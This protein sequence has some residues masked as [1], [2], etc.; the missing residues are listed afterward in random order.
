[1]YN[2]KSPL[3]FSEFSDDEFQDLVCDVLRENFRIMD[4]RVFG[5][6]GFKQYG[7]DVLA[8]YHGKEGTHCAV[9]AK[10]YKAYTVGNLNSALKEFLKH[11]DLW[12]SKGVGL[13]ILAFSC[14][15]NTPKFL[16]RAADFRNILFRD[17]GM[18]F[19]IWDQVVV[20]DGV[21][22]F[23]HV[24]SKYIRSHDVLDLLCGSDPQERA[25]MRL[26]RQEKEGLTFPPFEMDWEGDVS[27]Q[28]L[29]ALRQD[30][31]AGRSSHA[32]SRLRALQ[33][34]PGWLERRPEK[35][36]AFLRMAASLHLNV[37]GNEVAAR[38]AASEARTLAPH[39]N[40]LIF[41][42][43]LL[44]HQGHP[45][46]ALSLARTLET[47]PGA[48][49]AA[50]LLLELERPEDVLPVLDGRS[51]SDHDAELDRL[52]ALALAS[53]G[54]HQD[55]LALVKAR[56]TV[57]PQAVYLR[58]L[59]GILHYQLA[60]SP[61]LRT[62]ARLYAPL[63]ITP[64]L[65]R[66][67]AEGLSHIGSA[68]QAFEG[69]HNLTD[70]DVSFRIHSDLWWI[71]SLSV[72]EYDELR[73]QALVHDHLRGGTL[74]PEMALWVTFKHWPV[75]LS[76]HLGQLESHAS[77]NGPL[78]VVAWHLSLNDLDQA[79][80]I[81]NAHAQRLDE[82]DALVFRS[83]RN[84][85]ALRR[86]PPIPTL[87]SKLVEIDRAVHQLRE[88]IA[89]TGE[90]GEAV[91]DLLTYGVWWA[92]QELG[93]GLVERLQTPGAV[94]L[95]MMAAA[96]AGDHSRVLSLREANGVLLTGATLPTFIRQSVTQA[97]VLQGELPTAL[98]DAE[99][100]AREHPTAAHLLNL[101]RLYSA[102]ARMN[103][104]EPLLQRLLKV[105][106]A[107]F[108]DLLS[109]CSF[110]FAIND[111]RLAQRLYGQAARMWEAGPY[112]E[113][114]VL[115]G[116]QHGLKIGEAQMERFQMLVAT[117]KARRVRTF[118][119]DE[120]MALFRGPDPAAAVY[121]RGEVSVHHWRDSDPVTLLRTVLGDGGVPPLYSRSGTLRGRFRM[122]GDDRRRVLR[123]DLTGLLTC[124]QLGLLEQ[125][126]RQFSVC[127]VHE[128][129]SVL[130]Q[131][132]AG[133]DSS[134]PHR[135]LLNDLQGWLRDL[136]QDGRLRY[137]ATP[138]RASEMQAG[139]IL[140]GMAVL[141][142][143]PVG[144]DEQ[145]WVDDRW[146]Q[147]AA[148]SHGAAVTDT[149]GVLHDLH[150][151][152][153]ID[154]HAL[155]SRLQIL[156]R[157]G[158][159]FVP[160]TEQE[161]VYWCLQAPMAES[162]LTETEDLAL[163]RRYYAGV[164]G[165]DSPLQ[166]VQ[167]LEGRVVTGELPFVL[168]FLHESRH[169]LALAFRHPERAEAMAEWLFAHILLD[170]AALAVL[171][172]AFHPNGRDMDTLR[173]HDVTDLAMAALTFTE[174]QAAQFHRWLNRTLLQPR[175]ALDPLLPQRVAR[176]WHAQVADLRRDAAFPEQQAIG[177][178][179]NRI[180]DRLPFLHAAALNDPAYL[181][182][183]G[184]VQVQFVTWDGTALP[185]PDLWRTFPK[186]V[187]R[188][189]VPR[190][191]TDRAG[192]RWTLVWLPSKACVEVRPDG[193]EG[194]PFHFLPEELWLSMPKMSEREPFVREVLSALD[195]PA[196]EDPRVQTMLTG[197]T[198]L[199]RM[200]AFKTLEE[201]SSS[202]YYQALQKRLDT[203]P[204]RYPVSMDGWI[205]DDPTLILRHARLESLLTDPARPFAEQMRQ[206]AKT[207]IGDFGALEAAGRLL[208]L[209][210]ALPEEVAVALG[211]EQ[212]LSDL[213]ALWRV[214]KAS[215]TPV[216]LAHLVRLLGEATPQNR[217]LRV[218][219]ART[220]LSPGAHQATLA[221]KRALVWTVERLHTAVPSW[222]LSARL[223]AAWLHG[224]RLYISLLRA[225]VQ[226]ERMV[227]LFSE[228]RSFL[229]LE[230]LMT[231]FDEATDQAHPHLIEPGR[232]L[233]QLMVHAAP[234]LLPELRERVAE[235]VLNVHLDADGKP[236]ARMAALEFLG[237]DVPRPNS[238]GVVLGRPLAE[239]LAGELG[240]VA[241][242]LSPEGAAVYFSSMVGLAEVE[243][244][245]R[246]QMLTLVG[247]HVQRTGWSATQG[248]RALFLGTLDTAAWAP[249]WRM[250]GLIGA[251][252]LVACAHDAEQA[253]LVKASLKKHLE[254]QPD[255][256]Q[257]PMEVFEV[258]VHLSQVP[259][260][261]GSSLLRLA[262]L[263]DEL[264]SPYLNLRRG[265]YPL[266]VRMGTE[267]PVD[268]AMPFWT[269]LMAWRALAGVGELDW[270]E[271]EELKTGV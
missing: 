44:R 268:Q 102:T 171:P 212:R 187:Q 251:S 95:V 22:P 69:L 39:P 237:A 169:S 119:E 255:D 35:A 190:R 1:M 136:E 127:V 246:P 245:V 135:A 2:S 43:S 160:V 188:P 60:L 80:V 85:I 263:L 79:E 240:E 229:P 260:G 36:A 106:D 233:L 132:L 249:E 94:F 123:I 139:G 143:G 219:L 68:R 5:D 206:A 205:P 159:R 239:A 166:A 192:R 117:G 172:W 91:Q 31:Q 57:A 181:K 118:T 16:S 9:Q 152:G 271:G 61:A 111:P 180:E 37:H 130:T 51:H 257:L 28:L 49:M 261:T 234:D 175:I 140:R 209:P 46:E 18:R 12:K 145:L 220:L 177:V 138:E 244:A 47:V 89:G 150:R 248:L 67:N 235:H 199:S 100:L 162:R 96:H 6:R 210:V 129:V 116:L 207:L 81:L 77:P 88:F 250:R 70:L 134:D 93:E 182:S 64:T 131:M 50:A 264:A 75:N 200:E 141:M 19:E 73:A 242:T 214:L 21:R 221:L 115:Y 144:V 97:L 153:E 198:V 178:L 137:L 54:K 104:L 142:T 197:R 10:R 236:L 176:A 183:T 52:R 42:V 72:D 158:R 27:D 173:D 98:E 155:Y 109:A 121:S 25:Y 265:L 156:R 20:T 211:A 55:A 252:Y 65:L 120:V 168:E 202:R 32:L 164:F 133:L 189:G 258:L 17:H 45:D 124:A 194:Q 208:P 15:N 56:L 253:A 266:L 71:A 14:K 11:I 63:P 13:F 218:R 238:L 34:E 101:M 243:E 147:Q 148:E 247:Q 163:L 270:W 26:L 112:L 267:V 213:S 105:D 223:A 3:D 125:V 59:E 179:A 196:W 40:D 185:A 126:A 53:S 186:L 23:R 30:I 230:A 227:A 165:Q 7:I 231:P 110:A 76:L 215:G 224:H 38:Q 154:D 114:L 195:Q 8:P 191:L 161:L 48:L 226:P 41:D 128:Q 113:D 174:A 167:V 241:V 82:A 122:Q 170:P 193:H 103:S 86:S 107:G 62:P 87:H 92:F 269:T 99:L 254:H 83:W 33:A 157:H 108:S 216:T 225:G 201:A 58:L 256:A 217:A 222:P 151:R 4:A 78:A 24:A 262:K 66:A 90:L 259:D 184:R 29:Q 146:T 74:T 84:I 204:L 149:V 228:D 203:G 232:A